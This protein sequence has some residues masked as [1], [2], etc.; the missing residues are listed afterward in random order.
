MHV[1]EPCD[2]LTGAGLTV[3][4][5]S[6]GRG[7]NHPERG[8]WLC[9]RK[10]QVWSLLEQ[11]C[12]KATGAHAGLQGVCHLGHDLLCI[13]KYTG[14]EMGVTRHPLSLLMKVPLLQ[15]WFLLYVTPRG[16]PHTHPAQELVWQG[17]DEGGPWGQAPRIQI[18]SSAS[19]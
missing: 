16:P 3:A 1:N 12:S 18:P 13:K 8:S 6:P 17:G 7:V 10:P 19:Y 5:G 2:S 4:G 14:A 15:H 9:S 11:E